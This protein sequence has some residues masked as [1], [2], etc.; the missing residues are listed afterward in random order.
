MYARRREIGCF[1]HYIY[2]LAMN[3]ERN[4]MKKT[5]NAGPCD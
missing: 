3:E 4:K 2:S 1:L 5:N